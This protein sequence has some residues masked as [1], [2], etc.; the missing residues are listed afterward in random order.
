METVSLILNALF[1]ANYH[2]GFA[3]RPN[4]RNLPLAVVG[5]FHNCLAECA[6]IRPGKNGCRN[7]TT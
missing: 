1:S 3:E 4:H 2:T 6:D 7:Q 5:E